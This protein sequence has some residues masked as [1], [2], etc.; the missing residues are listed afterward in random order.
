MV[1]G[2]KGFYRYTVYN[3]KTDFPVIVDGTARECA[4]AMGLTISSF[5]SAVSRS[6]TE[7]YKK[8]HITKDFADDLEQ[9]EDA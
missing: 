4:K 2:Q 1:P 3:N 6:G 7:K 8:W 9:E 5:Y